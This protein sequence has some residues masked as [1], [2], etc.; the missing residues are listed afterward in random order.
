MPSL[1]KFIDVAVPVN[2][3]LTSRPSS[4]P[5]AYFMSG[6]Q[7]ITQ[8][9]DTPSHWVTKVGGH[10]RVRH[11]HTRTTSGRAA[12]WKITEG[13]TRSGMVTFHRLTRTS[14]LRPAEL[15]PA[16]VLDAR[17][18]A[19]LARLGPRVIGGTCVRG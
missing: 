10:P 13:T 4:S 15:D 5:S 7:T 14:A 9:D 8:T 18:P 12:A 19:S 17:V 2:T 3:A 6:A 11:G 1:T 16:A